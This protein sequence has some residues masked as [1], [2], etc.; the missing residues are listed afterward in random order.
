MIKVGIADIERVLAECNAAQH[1]ARKVETLTQKWEARLGELEA[2]LSEAQTRL[3][4]ANEQT[5]AELVFA[6]THQARL[7]ELES[8]Q[9]RERAQVDLEGY[10]A[11]LQQGLLKQLH[12][13]FQ[14]L[15][16]SQGLDLMLST[17]N[18]QIPYVG[19]SVDLT[20]PLLSAMNGR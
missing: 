17:P 15:G 18:L 1:V 2:R 14:K 4:E 8:R 13:T 12:E 5:P 6:L 11:H 9:L 3:G 20:K 10:A 7:L 19:A 16:A